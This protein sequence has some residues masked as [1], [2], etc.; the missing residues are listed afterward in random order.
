MQSFVVEVEG[1]GVTPVCSSE[2]RRG[3]MD[4]G[5]NLGSFQTRGSPASFRQC[6]PKFRSKIEP[7]LGEGFDANSDFWEDSGRGKSKHYKSL[8]L[9]QAPH[10]SRV[11][12]IR[13]RR[14]PAC[15]EPRTELGAA[16]GENVG[17][18]VGSCQT[19]QPVVSAARG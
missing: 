19:P 11:R 2:S 3:S 9:L 17:P 13:L 14:L 1:V 18:I 8:S 12:W 15:V 16:I 10:A 4:V 5:R 6:L 7:L